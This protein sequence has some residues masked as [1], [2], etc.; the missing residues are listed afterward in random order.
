MLLQLFAHFRYEVFYFIKLQHKSQVLHLSI[1]SDILSR[2]LIR[3]LEPTLYNY[4]HMVNLR[5]SKCHS[6]SDQVFIRV[7]QLFN[8]LVVNQ[9]YLF[10]T[11]QPVCL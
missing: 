9:M 10:E 3:W 6:D 5:L 1:E 11:L 8:Q 7:I 2:P 4:R